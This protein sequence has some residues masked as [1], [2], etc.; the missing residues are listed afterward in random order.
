M[1]MAFGLECAN[2][3]C[4]E[5]IYDCILE[6]FPPLCRKLCGAARSARTLALFSVSVRVR[7]HQRFEVSGGRRPGPEFRARVHIL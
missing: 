6:W 7:Q 2:V 5:H 1:L 3:V 4:A